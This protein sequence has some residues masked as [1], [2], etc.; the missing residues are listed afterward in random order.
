[1]PRWT[2]LLLWGLAACGSNDT[3]ARD[4]QNPVAMQGWHTER[5]KVPTQAEF[6]ALA[7]TCEAKGG[8]L[9]S[10]LAKMGLR[11]SP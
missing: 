2:L 6:T 5:G 11:R 3:A 8:S 7:A 9:D 4:D 10:C 1:M